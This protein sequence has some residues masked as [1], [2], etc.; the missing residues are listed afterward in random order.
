MSKGVRWPDIKLLI[1]AQE[2]TLFL[3]KQSAA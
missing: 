1:F 2:K 3:R